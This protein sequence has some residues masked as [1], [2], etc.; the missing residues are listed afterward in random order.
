[1]RL[2]LSYIQF[3][4]NAVSINRFRRTGSSFC[5]IEGSEKNRPSRIHLLAETARTWGPQPF[6][7]TAVCLH[8]RV[9]LRLI[10]LGS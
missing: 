5:R 8:Y 2:I 1:M 7:V 10:Q 9:T 3:I 4:A 6:N